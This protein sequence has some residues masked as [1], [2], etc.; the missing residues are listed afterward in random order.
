VAGDAQR[1]PEDRP[2]QA[3]LRRA[4][5]A[6]LRAP[7]AAPLIAPLLP[8]WLDGRLLPGGEARLPLDDSAYQSG[9]GCYT[10][11]R[12]QGGR[13]R[14]AARHA[15]RLVR[16]AAALGLGA[17]EPAAP[18][19]AFEELGHAAFGGEEGVLRLQVSRSADGTTRL[20]GVARPTGAEPAAWTAIVAPFAHEGPG[21]WGGAKHTGHPRVALARAAARAA[22]CDEALLFDAA[23]RLVEGARTSLVVVRGDGRLVA[24][25][26]AR[27]GVRSVAREIVSQAEGE[28]AETDLLLPDL[29]LAREIVALNAVRGAAAVVRLA[30]RQVGDGA[31]GRHAVRLREVIARAE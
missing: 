1:P 31:P 22:D 9:L 30:G 13:A 16:D 28:L 20:V 2:A 10:T 21:P 26:L 24:P 4:A 15:A 17:L 12:W 23:G 25:P 29:L 27:G 11:T 5:P 6:R 7:R 18:L 8:A 14:F 19:A 3:D